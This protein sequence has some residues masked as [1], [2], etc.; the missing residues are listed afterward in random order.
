M[1]W[2]PISSA[3]WSVVDYLHMVSKQK[4]LVSWRRCNNYCT[5]VGI[6]RAQRVQNAAVF[7]ARF[8]ALRCLILVSLWFSAGGCG[9]CG[10]THS[11]WNAEGCH[12]HQ[13]A[14]R[15]RWWSQIILPGGRPC[16]WPEASLSTG[17]GSPCPCRARP[18]VKY[19]GKHTNISTSKNLQR[20]LPSTFTTIS[21][22]R[23]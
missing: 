4:V 1:R 10:V 11:G 19:L 3:L 15:W 14:W 23:K 22:S 9:C 13:W 5:Y 16:L 2:C 12:W 17:P 21:L 8:V 7:F 6:L 20:V 18:C